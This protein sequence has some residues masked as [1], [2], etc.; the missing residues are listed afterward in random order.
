MSLYHAHYVWYSSIT[1]I[2]F[3]WNK[4]EPLSSVLLNMCTQHFL[5]SCDW[6]WALTQW[7]VWFSMFLE[8]NNNFIV[9]KIN[10]IWEFSMHNFI[11][12]LSQIT[13]K[14]YFTCSNVFNCVFLCRCFWL[15]LCYGTFLF[16]F[17]L[18]FVNQKSIE[19]NGFWCSF[20]KI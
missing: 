18:F 13:W 6:N 7:N 14:M 11:E 3:R 15:C 10:S 9:W 8:C 5:C 1:C 16:S 19:I 4:L 20:S 2:Q 12:L 17:L